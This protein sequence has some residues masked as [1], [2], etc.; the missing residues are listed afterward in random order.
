MRRSFFSNRLRAGARLAGLRRPPGLDRNPL[1]SPEQPPTAERSTT[2][3]Q[4][5]PHR[6]RLD[7]RAA[8][9][10][11]QEL[12][13][14]VHELTADS[15]VRADRDPGRRSRRRRQL[16]LLG[17]GRSR[18]TTTPAG[19]RSALRW[20]VV[21]DRRSARSAT[22][23][24]HYVYAARVVDLRRRRLRTSPGAAPG[25]PPSATPEPGVGSGRRLHCR[26]PGDERTA[27]VAGMAGLDG[28]ARLGSPWPRGWK[29]EISAIA[30]SCH[31]SLSWHASAGSSIGS[32]WRRETRIECLETERSHL[33]VR[34][35]QH[36]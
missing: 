10:Q 20:R 33:Q 36:G 27:V 31:P 11:P 2:A 4:Y 17:A 15:E 23:G 7:H 29:A 19:P 13:D 5:P 9:S 16:T 18:W 35:L 3:P 22:T 30:S 6:R 1:D 14:L 8:S 26:A 32:P 25:R 12:Q 34:R 28:P 21:R 24:L